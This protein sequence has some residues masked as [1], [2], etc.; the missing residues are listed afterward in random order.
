[1]NW[2]DKIKQVFF[3]EQDL[4][5]RYPDEYNQ[6]LA[7]Q[8]KI[9]AAGAQSQLLMSNPIFQD[10][11]A[12]MYLLLDAEL[13][14]ISDT[15]PDAEMRIRWVRCQRRALRQVC[16][17][18]DNKIAAQQSLEKANQEEKSNG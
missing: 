4:G 11:V 14:A 17:M 6:E 12:E 9:I 18:L 8:S 5:I 13:D 10:A 16:A 1:M 15:D 2:R 7:Q 3:T